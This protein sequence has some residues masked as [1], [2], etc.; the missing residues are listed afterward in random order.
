[1]Q[2]RSA[3]TR[4]PHAYR[5]GIE[6]AEAVRDITPEVVF[7]FSTIDYG[8]NADILEGLRDGLEDPNCLIIGNSGDGFYE[9]RGAFSFGASVL[10]LNSH[11]QATWQLSLGDNVTADPISATRQALYPL[12]DCQ[13]IFMVS[14]FHADA[15]LVEQVLEHEIPVPVIGG[16][17]ADD[18]Q[19]HQC[20]LYA[21]DR[22]VTDRILALG[23]RGQINF[24]IF[25]ENSIA[26][27]GSI[28]VINAAEGMRIDRINHLPAM[29]FIEQAT[30]KPV[31][32]SDRGV[33]SLTIL[34]D[35]PAIKRLRSV[36]EDFTTTED[37]LMLYGG[38]AVGQRVQ[39]CMAQPE[40][41]I[42][43]TYH[44]VEQAR[45]EWEHQPVAALVVS[46]A[47]RKTLLGPQLNHEIDVLRQNFGDELAMVG[48][49][50]LGEIG[51][52]RVGSRYSANL[53][54]N[55]TYVLLLIGS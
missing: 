45:H 26:P 13:L 43:E 54:H 30:G 21:N 55:M 11:G 48:F 7:L 31:L 32:R 47:G 6:L 19:W 36:S 3:S 16:F 46:C 42:T 17:A 34:D 15:S 2:A 22:V 39:V 27:V 25:I 8:D 49:P 4:T 20:A 24:S 38:I 40:A 12:R 53:F 33:T 9:S 1:M 5:A 35:N 23:V 51:P 10:A 44:L 37:S 18:H 52:L 50:S 14:D 29:Q 28:G 41:I